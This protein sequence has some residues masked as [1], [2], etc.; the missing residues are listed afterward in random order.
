MSSMTFQFLLLARIFYNYK[1]RFTY[2]FTMENI[3]ITIREYNEKYFKQ[4]TI[5]F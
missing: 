2:P 1:N 3:V 5:F 4:V